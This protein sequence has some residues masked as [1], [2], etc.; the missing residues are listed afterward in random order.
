MRSRSFEFLA[1]TGE[2]GYTQVPGKDSFTRALIFALEA[3]VDERT[4]GRF[5]T[6]ELLNKIKTDAPDFPRDQIPMLIKREKK[7]SAGRIMLHPLRKEGRDDELERREAASLDPFKGHALTLHFDFSEKPSST[8]L[9]LLGREMNDFFQRN[10]GVNRVRWGGMRPSIAARAAK[11]L[12]DRLRRRRASTRLQE[13]KPS[14]GSPQ[15]ELAEN[16]SD[17]LTPSSLAPHSPR[18][19]ESVRKCSPEFNLANPAD[20]GALPPSMPLHSTDES[21]DHAQDH[22]ERRKRQRSAAS[23]EGYS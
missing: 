1:A 4:D 5:T 11:T 17:P 23:D 20:V 16:A 13:A 6:V 14:D 10:V 9:E 8:Y 19:L 21:E 7:H 18:I 22:R 2:M 15:V 12:Q 3:L